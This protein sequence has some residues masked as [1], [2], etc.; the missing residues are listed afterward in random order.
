MQATAQLSG[1]SVWRASLPLLEVRRLLG[2]HRQTCRHPH[3]CCASKFV[4]YSI[5]YRPCWRST[6]CACVAPECMKR[7][8]SH[9]NP[10]QELTRAA[11]R[12]Y[13]VVSH[14]TDT[15]QAFAAMWRRNHRLTGG[16]LRAPVEEVH[17]PGLQHLRIPAASRRALH[18]AVRT[19]CGSGRGSRVQTRLLRARCD[20]VI[21][22]RRRARCGAY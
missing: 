17:V 6:F 19:S 8:C 21:Y 1:R 12:L 10:A 13:T 15:P 5:C 20:G 14:G 3:V 11:R 2:H 18:E 7:E 16:A 4:M 9:L 22:H